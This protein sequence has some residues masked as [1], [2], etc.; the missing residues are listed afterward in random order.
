MFFCKI[1]VGMKYLWKKLD[2]PV[3]ISWVNYQ[4]TIV[5]VKVT[6]KPALDFAN[7]KIS[8]FAVGNNGKLF[9]YCA[10]LGLTVPSTPTFGASVVLNLGLIDV[11]LIVED[12]FNKKNV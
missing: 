5:S 11:T 1:I 4:V 9:G 8:I 3:N 6:I 2:Y 10:T 12:K 7:R